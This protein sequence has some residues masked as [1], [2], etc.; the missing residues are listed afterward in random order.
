VKRKRSLARQKSDDALAERIAQIKQEHPFWGYRR[1]WATL[2][3][4][5]GLVCNMKRIYRIMRE[6]N[7]LCAKKMRPKIADRSHRPKPKAER[8][9]QIWGTDMTKIFVEGHGWTY[10][11]VV[12]DWYTK[13]IV[14]LKSGPHSKSSDWLEALD[15]ALNSQFPRGSRG[16][17][18]KL[19]SDNG[20]QPTSVAYMRYCSNVD[21]DQ[22][23]TSYNNPK[24]NAE[25]E[26]FMRTMKE[27][28]LWLQEWKSS[29]ELTKELVSWVERYNADY[30]H[31]SLK[32]RSPNDV[33]KNYYK[34][35]A[36]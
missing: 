1:V 15:Q 19:V 30:L 24:G 18:L 9:N 16:K 31:S 17:G 12:L 34:F 28:L 4:R 20:C 36:A 11:T 26:R 25:T 33:E 10:I 8:P 13:K 29:D 21:V 5:D 3:Y 32:Y 14:G 23:Y 22:I 6:R 7:L 2:R 35:E 27:E